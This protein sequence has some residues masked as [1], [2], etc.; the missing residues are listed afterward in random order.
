MTDDRAAF[1]EARESQII[2]CEPRQD[3]ADPHPCRWYCM[4]GHE[5]DDKA[6]IPGVCPLEKCERRGANHG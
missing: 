6:A 5:L 2:I 4:R 3:C 1:T